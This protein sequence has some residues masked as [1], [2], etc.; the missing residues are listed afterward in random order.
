MGVFGERHLYASRTVAIAILASSLWTVGRLLPGR[1]QHPPGG[2]RTDGAW[3]LRNWWILE[4]IGRVE[5]LMES[6]LLA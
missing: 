6:A 4:H 1:R 3:S 5:G 2:P